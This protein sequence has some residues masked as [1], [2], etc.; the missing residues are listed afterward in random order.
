MKILVDARIAVT[1]TTMLSYIKGCLEKQP[2]FFG[3]IIR[4]YCNYSKPANLLI[5]LHPLPATNKMNNLGDVSVSV[6]QGYTKQ[7]M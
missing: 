7:F 1:N 2:F 4:T 6:L 3:Q 5:T